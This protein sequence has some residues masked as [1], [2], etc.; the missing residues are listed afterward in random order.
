[1]NIHRF[2]LEKK[3]ELKEY[4][5]KI[6]RNLTLFHFDAIKKTLLCLHFPLSDNVFIRFIF[7]NAY[8]TSESI[9]NMGVCYLKYLLF[10]S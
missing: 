2:P 6:L 9:K 3:N 1:M 7:F 5:L 10:Q 8:L 4:F